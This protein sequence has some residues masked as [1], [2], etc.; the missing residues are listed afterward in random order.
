MLLRFSKSTM[1]SHAL[2]Q[3][4]NATKPPKFRSS[5]RELSKHDIDIVSGG[6]IEYFTSVNRN[7]YENNRK[8][9][10]NNIT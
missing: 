9:R 5:Y 6:I 1:P 4:L 8:K 10:E 3:L 2:P 7:N